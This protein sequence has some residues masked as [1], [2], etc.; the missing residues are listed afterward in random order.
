MTKLLTAPESAEIGLI[1]SQLELAGIP[2][3]IR[4][5]NLGT[6][7]GLAPFNAELWILR[8]EDLGN[9]QELLAAWKDAPMPPEAGSP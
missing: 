2:C 1:R 8:D 7:L 5:D 3:E 4:N 9:A 6:A